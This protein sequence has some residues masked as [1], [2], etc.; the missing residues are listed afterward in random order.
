M[1][2]PTAASVRVQRVQ[3]DLPNPATPLG[4]RLELLGEDCGWGLI[5]TS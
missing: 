1:G 5:Q 2:Q 4:L 3:D